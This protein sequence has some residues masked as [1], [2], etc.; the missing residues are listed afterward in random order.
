MIMQNPN[1]VLLK[2]KEMNTQN[3]LLANDFIMAYAFEVIDV[4]GACMV[5]RRCEGEPCPSE[6]TRALKLALGSVFTPQMSPHGI[7]HWQPS[8]ASVVKHLPAH[9]C[10]G[11]DLEGSSGPMGVIAQRKGHLGGSNVPWDLVPDPH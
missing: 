3:S 2:T 10:G 1:S 7:N 5:Q 8:P 6:L 4:H 9:H 11:R